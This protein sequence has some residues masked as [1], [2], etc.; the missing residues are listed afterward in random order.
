M[1]RSHCPTKGKRCCHLPYS[2]QAFWE[3]ETMGVAK[4]IPTLWALEISSS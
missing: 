4:D 2:A 1:A 3:P